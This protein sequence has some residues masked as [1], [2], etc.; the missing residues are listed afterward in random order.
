[1]LLLGGLGVCITQLSLVGPTGKN[2]PWLRLAVFV[3]SG[4]VW[5]LG[6]LVSALVIKVGA[7]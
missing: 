3:L 2:D 5:A 7:H 6:C 1:M 4:I